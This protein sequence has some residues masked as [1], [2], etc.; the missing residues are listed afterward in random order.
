MGNPG[1]SHRT[2]VGV[3][4]GAHRDGLSQLPRASELCL[5]PF[6]QGGMAAKNGT[7]QYL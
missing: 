5:C 6:G 1:A 4:S 7:L 3:V 2:G